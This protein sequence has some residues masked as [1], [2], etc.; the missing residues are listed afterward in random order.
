MREEGGFYDDNQGEVSEEMLEIRRV[1][2][3]I[4]E[5]K[6]LNK[7]ESRLRRKVKK[8]KLPR[9]TRKEAMQPEDMVDGLAEYG[10][11]LS[12]RKGHFRLL[13]CFLFVFLSYAFS[14][15]SFSNCYN[16]FS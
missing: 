14:E 10:I 1:A 4:R 2:E 5:K 13:F 12:D 6:E 3:K 8:A 9:N 15:D 16:L 7:I 11:D